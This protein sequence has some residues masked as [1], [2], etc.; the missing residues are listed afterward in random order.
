MYEYKSQY[1]PSGPLA[2]SCSFPLLYFL[3][4]HIFLGAFPQDPCFL[5]FFT[6]I[7]VIFF[8]F[9]IFFTYIFLGAFPQDPYL[10]GWLFQYS[11]YHIISRRQKDFF[12]F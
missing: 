1:A 9:Y 4:S 7:F 8:N 6:F 10:A 2:A 5:L 11:N 12:Q 3:I